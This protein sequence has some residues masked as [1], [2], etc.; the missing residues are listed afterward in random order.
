MQSFCANN[1]SSLKVQMTQRRT[2]KHDYNLKVQKFSNATTTFS[3]P[4]TLPLLLRISW[5]IKAT[6]SMEFHLSCLFT[7]FLAKIFRNDP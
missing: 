2:T 3:V 7:A 4:P 6:R 1:T 5:L